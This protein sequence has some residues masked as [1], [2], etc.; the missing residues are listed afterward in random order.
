M[1]CRS[2]HKC[3][4]WVAP[5]CLLTST[6]RAGTHTHTHSPVPV[7]LLNPPRPEVGFS[8]RITCL[9]PL[10]RSWPPVMPPLR[11]ITRCFI[12]AT[13]ESSCGRFSAPS[14]RRGWSDAA[15][16]SSLQTNSRWVHFTALSP[17]EVS[18]ERCV[19]LVQATASP[20]RIDL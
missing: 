18:V 10:S 17:K 6:R 14:D 11:Q 9:H 4:V 19:C 16:C 5:L 2:S 12:A 7:V 20:L 3:V 8:E 15:R 1:W 13:L